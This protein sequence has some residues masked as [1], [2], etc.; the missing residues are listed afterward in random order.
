MA[1]F[2]NVFSA[3]FMRFFDKKNWKNLNVG[4]IIKYDEERVCFFEEKTFSS[5]KIAS[6]PNWEGAK[7]AGVSR[8]SCLLLT[9]LQLI[10]PKIAKKFERCS[11][12]KNFICMLK[13]ENLDKFLSL[14]FF[15]KLIKRRQIL[16]NSIK[17]LRNFQR[18]TNFIVRNLLWIVYNHSKTVR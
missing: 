10:Q 17:I 7:Y 2:E 3:L 12:L 14:K 4:K 1:L 13:L 6:L 11:Q 16:L 15:K 9:Q 8:P 18:K 5:F